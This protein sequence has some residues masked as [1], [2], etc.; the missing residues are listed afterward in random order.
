M[1][2]VR[3]YLVY[4]LAWT[5]FAAIYALIVHAQGSPL[6]DA[7]L[8]GATSVGIAALLGVPLRR[9]CAAVRVRRLGW[10]RFILLHALL[11]SIFSAV[12][13]GAI[14]A[15]IR[16]GAPPERWQAFAANALWW[17]FVT[18]FLLYGVVAGV[19]T[20]LA[21]GGLLREQEALA[22]RAEA[23]RVR[24]ELRALRAQLNP[25]FLFNTLHSITALVRSDPRAAESALERFGML[26]RHVLDTHREQ[27][28]EVP[29]PEELDFVRS[30][31]AL[32]KMRLADRL[33]V[34]EEIDGDAL[35][36]YILTFSLQP[37]VENAVRHGLAPLPQGG[38]LRIAA[39]ITGDMLHLEVADD[40]AGAHAASAQSSDGVGLQ[41][42][43]QRLAARFGNLA[44]LEITSAPN[45]GFR[46]HIA[47]PVVLRPL[48]ARVTA[49]H[50]VSR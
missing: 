38:T 50:A 47:M 1:K 29:L 23:L 5:P 7:I 31:L 3:F 30:Y 18:G 14:A 28:D 4:A 8:S 10:T 21:T 46:V 16:F 45:E 20:A 2:S 49:E 44:R 27:R 26:M 13:T 17:Q 34:V 35:E 39:S 48:P 9:I 25:H 6:G 43:R 37:L 22:A 36:C 40:G 11:G 32:E 19:F 41:V 12:W 24:A 15:M 42:V 33:R